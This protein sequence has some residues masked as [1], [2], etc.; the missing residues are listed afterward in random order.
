MVR[1]DTNQGGWAKHDRIPISYTY[2][3]HPNDQI[4][5]EDC[6]FIFN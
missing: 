6:I 2:T 4:I 5:K 1:D 3:W